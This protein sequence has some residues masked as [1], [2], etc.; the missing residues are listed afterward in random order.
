[1]VLGNLNDLLLILKENL[2][3]HLRRP[4]ILKKKKISQVR[5]RREKEK[6]DRKGRR[7]RY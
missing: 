3:S 1:M 5:M 6:K 7:K 4:S 2:P